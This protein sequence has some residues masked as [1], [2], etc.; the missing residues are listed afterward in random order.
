[1]NANNRNR[2][3]ALGGPPALAKRAA[4]R[5]KASCYPVAWEESSYFLRILMV[6]SPL[7]F[8]GV[9]AALPCRLPP[10]SFCLPFPLGLLLSIPAMSETANSRRTALVCL[11]LVLV[12]AA[13]YW[14]AQIGRGARRER[15]AIS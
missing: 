9:S 12:T 5:E 13:V 10:S 11:A 15:V 6:F 14:P 4:S 1:M 8:F 7:S 3:D 2:T